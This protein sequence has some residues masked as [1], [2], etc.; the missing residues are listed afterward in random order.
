MIDKV[1]I[2]DTTG[3]GITHSVTS[4]I[5]EMA[6]RDE[7]EEI[8]NKINN[9]INPKLNNIEK[10]LNNKIP[11]KIEKLNRKI[12]DNNEYYNHEIKTI[13]DNIQS[14][15]TNM[16]NMYSSMETNVI[17]TIF[18]CIRYIP[19]L[20]AL[21]LSKPMLL[22]NKI[23]KLYT[24]SIIYCDDYENNIHSYIILVN[25]SYDKTSFK[26]K[27]KLF[28]TQCKDIKSKGYTY[29][30]LVEMTIKEQEVYTH[31]MNNWRSNK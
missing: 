12:K 11:N 10:R 29:K 22:F 17:P 19:I 23:F 26:E 24:L 1:I 15:N 16:E 5:N 9:D 21:I 3:I 6:K 13:T 28:K 30:K 8:I 18:E 25:I 31:K 7:V 27:Y 4:V 14:T 20:L 2:G